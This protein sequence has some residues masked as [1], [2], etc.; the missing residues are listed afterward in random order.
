MTDKGIL[1]VVSGP[2]GVGKGTVNRLLCGKGSVFLS[3][4]ATTR[5][6]RDGEIDGEHYFFVSDEKFGA[7]IDGGELLEHAEYVNHYY[8][9]PAAPVDKY[10][11]EGKDVILEIDTVG[12]FKVREKRPDAV[13]VFLLP[14]SLEE[15]ERRLR[16]RG[17]EEESVVQKRLDFAKTEIGRIDKFDYVVVNENVETA[18]SELEEI[19]KA[20]RLRVLRRIAKFGKIFDL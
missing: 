11:N 16:F 13:L 18:A 19:I 6:P 8:G 20:E 4:S 14:P 17:T 9:T 3:V 15:L 5:K 7:M 1:L 2:S 12:A 10:L